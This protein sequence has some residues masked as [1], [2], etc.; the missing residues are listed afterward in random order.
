MT[1]NP[2]CTVLRSVQEQAHACG[3]ASL[4]TAQRDVL[5]HH[6]IISCRNMS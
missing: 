1:E 5:P 2:L 6:S 3:A 4:V